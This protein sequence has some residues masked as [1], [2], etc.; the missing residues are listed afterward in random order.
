MHIKPMNTFTGSDLTV[1]HID[2][3]R[4][5]FHWAKH[6]IYRP[7][8]LIA[9]AGT[10]SIAYKDAF[11]A[12]L[13]GDM[14]I[15]DALPRHEFTAEPGWTYS[16]FDFNEK[17]D[18]GTLKIPCNSAVPGVRIAHFEGAEL[19]R[20]KL[21]M[22]EIRQ[23]HPQSRNDEQ[24][25]ALAL[26]RLILARFARLVP[27]EIERTRSSLYRAELRL[28]QLD[29]TD[30]MTDVAQ[31]CGMSKT[32]FFRKFRLEYGCSPLEYRYNLIISQAKYL[33]CS[34]N[35]QIQ[36]IAHQL[37]FSDPFYFTKFFCS[38]TGFTPSRYRKQMNPG[39]N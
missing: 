13:P 39:P 23:I 18:G 8:G 33:L 37:N 29:L 1:G 21:E 6:V 10:G 15:M 11:Q 17:L 27:L 38:R 32:D 14:L 24:G 22:R 4:K 26:L 16:F 30:T 19:A 5:R 36:E 34:T 2:N 31:A 25:V 12:I 9:L 35:F 20:L 28:K 7:G 3:I